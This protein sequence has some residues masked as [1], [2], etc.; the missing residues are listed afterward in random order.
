V[1]FRSNNEA[2]QPVMDALALLD[3][4]TDSDA[5]HYDRA[6]TVPLEHVVPDD[7]R[8]AVLDPDTRP[9]RMHPV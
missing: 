9:D 3:R 1:E 2:F 6:E 5:E 8:E 7:W 4:Y